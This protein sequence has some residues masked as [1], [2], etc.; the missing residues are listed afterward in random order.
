MRA[1]VTGPGL[2]ETFFVPPKSLTTPGASLLFLDNL[3]R[4]II[5]Q[6]SL[7]TTSSQVPPCRTMHD[8]TRSSDRRMARQ[9]TGRG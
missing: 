7:P 5:A 9:L 2:G 6:L 4:F 8:S 1:L 3:P